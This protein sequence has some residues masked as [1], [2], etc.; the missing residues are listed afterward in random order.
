MSD[1]NTSKKLEGITGLL[2]GF[3]LALGFMIYTKTGDTDGEGG[4]QEAGLDGAK[5]S[6]VKKISIQ[7]SNLE[8][9]VPLHFDR[10]SKS[11]AGILPSSPG[12]PQRT[13]S[14]V[15]DT[16]ETPDSQALRTRMTTSGGHS[17]DNL[18]DIISLEQARTQTPTLTL[19]LMYHRFPTPA[20]RGDIWV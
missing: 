14:A 17:V 5:T 4:Q 2:V 7:N 13:D 11:V 20:P 12:N 16:T 18:G 9:G 15:S 1:D 8:D 6:I 3:L 10:L 19:T